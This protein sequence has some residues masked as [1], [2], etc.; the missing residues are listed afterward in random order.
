[1]SEEIAERERFMCAT[2]EDSII[3]VKKYVNGRFLSPWKKAKDVGFK[4]IFLI[5]LKPG[6]RIKRI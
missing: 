5:L 1:M 3:T 2:L 6:D 4:Y